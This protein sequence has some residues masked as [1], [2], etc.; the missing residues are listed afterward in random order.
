MNLD[1]WL[2]EEPRKRINSDQKEKSLCIPASDIEDGERYSR[3]TE[4]FFEKR[5]SI[6]DEGN[7]Q[8]KDGIFNRN[9]NL[10]EQWLV[11]NV[12]KAEDKADITNGDEASRTV[13][14]KKAMSHLNVVI[15]YSL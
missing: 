4:Y 1:H 13:A 7:E 9:L 11:A 10:R 3:L 2:T 15:P 8:T 14:L 6:D 5:Y 12:L